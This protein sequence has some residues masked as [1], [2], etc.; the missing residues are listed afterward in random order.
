ML[1]SL[2]RKRIILGCRLG[3]PFRPGVPFLRRHGIL[4]NQKAGVK[5]AGIWRKNP[6]I[7]TNKIQISLWW[8]TSG[9]CTICVC[10]DL[11]VV[12]ISLPFGHAIRL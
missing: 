9:N 3:V 4:E 8:I 12:H 6:N 5:F 10:S 1:R 2:S 7:S 11:S